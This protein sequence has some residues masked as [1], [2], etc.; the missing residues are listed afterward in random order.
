[1]SDDQQRDA[2]RLQRIYREQGDR[3]PGPGV[4]QRIRARARSRVRSS[5]AP[6]PAHWLGGAAVAAS[7]FV[8]VSIATRIEPP[9]PEPRGTTVQEAT[10]AQSRPAA[11]TSRSAADN[12]AAAMRSSPPAAG[13]DAAAG[14]PTVRA[15]PDPGIDAAALERGARA[16]FEESA[17]SAETRLQPDP[18]LGLER[19]SSAGL[20]DDQAADADHALWLIE[21]L[22]A[23]GNT[24]EARTRIEAFE[25]EHPAREIPESLLER[26]QQLEQNPPQD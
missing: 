5:S 24:D 9:R 18:E 8:V 6:R 4:D 13:A 2:E 3:E 25:A 22:I 12:Q 19:T 16:R 7:L 11:E 20:V 15:R 17:R 10:D 26:L 23:V 21:R 1:M 14:E